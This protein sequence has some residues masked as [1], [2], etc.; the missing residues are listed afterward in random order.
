M[1]PSWR[2]KLREARVAWNSG[3]YDEAGALLAEDSL[4][5]FLPAKRLAQDVASK[6][7]E[8]AGDR[9]ACGDSSAGWQDLAV[10]DRLGGQAE[11]ITQIRQQYAERALGEARR[12]L[13]SGQAAAALSRLE[14]LRRKGLSSAASRGLQQ[15]ATRM[16]EAEQAAAH[17]RFNEAS[18]AVA[19]A[20][21]IAA[22]QAAQGVTMEIVRQLERQGK[23][24]ARLGVECHR[25]SSALHEALSRQDW[26]AALSA[27][28]EL[29]AIA[30]RH[31]A[32]RQ[33]RRRAWK[34]VGMDVTS[35]GRA[36]PLAG[37]VSLALGAAGGAGAHHSTRPGTGSCEGDTV[38]G[39]DKPRR[40]L[41]WIDAVGGFLI[42]LDDEIVLGQPSPGGPIALPILADLSRRHAVIRRDGGAY[43]LEPLHRTRVDGKEVTG[44]VV[45]ADNQ[46][47]ELG[48]SVRLRF[49]KPHALSAT[50]RLVLESSHKTQPSADAVLLMSDSCVLGPSG[51]CH[52]SCRDWQHDVVLYR[53][54]EKLYCRAEVP[55][56]VDGDRTTGS[57]EVPSGARIEGEDFSFTLEEAT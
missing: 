38:T 49:T 11:A 16:V 5:E 30:P 19:R 34:A 12:N 54:S 28:E 4:R 55:L 17:G 27:A 36:R 41:L 15:L 13:A 39:S 24:L 45:L 43:V 51:H 47:I 32:A 46:L 9:F 29:L 10:A 23:E 53:Q 37:C 50:A 3:R 18:A 6:M 48:E 1:F 20:Q 40:M 8:R 22:E 26:S 2:F 56:T 35:A 7:V 42:C 33:A 52:V 57:M 25:L 44:P 21:R 14:K 31:S